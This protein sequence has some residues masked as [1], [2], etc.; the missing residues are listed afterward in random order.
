MRNILNHKFKDGIHDEVLLA[1]IMKMLMEGLF[2][3]HKQSIVHRDIKCSNILVHG[4]GQVMLSDFGVSD[5]IKRGKKKHAFV[6][7][8]CWMAPEV[9]D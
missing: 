1:S 3:L 6:G 4:D 2:Y 5:T 9:V 8:P 7:S